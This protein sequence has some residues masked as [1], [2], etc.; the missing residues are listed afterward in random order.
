MYTMN[1]TGLESNLTY[2][3]HFQISVYVDCKPCP[4]RYICELS[5]EP[6][7]SERSGGRGLLKTRIRATP[8]LTHPNSC[9]TFF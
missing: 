5:E 3:E 1:F 6:E 4:P 2:N 7:V 9:G 8:E